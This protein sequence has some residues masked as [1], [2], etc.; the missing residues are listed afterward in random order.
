MITMNETQRARRGHDFLPP[1]DE[2]AEI[3]AL[4]ETDGIPAEAKLIPLHYFAAS[5]D[6]WIA[7]IGMEDGHPVAYGYAR[8]ASYPEGAEWGYADLAELEEVNAHHGLV[9]VERDLHWQ[10]R[11][12]GEITEAQR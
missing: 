9:I 1:A 11:K 10:P 3:P 7:E 12:F 8:L 4:Y 2:L 5:G 6:W